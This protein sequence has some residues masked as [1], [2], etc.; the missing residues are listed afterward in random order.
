MVKEK[1]MIGKILGAVA[2]QRIAKEAGGISGTRGALLGVGAATLLR[3]MSPLAI[4]AFAIGGY[5]AKKRHEKRG[6]TAKG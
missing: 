5:A 1:H 4:V 2:G 6:G 3:R